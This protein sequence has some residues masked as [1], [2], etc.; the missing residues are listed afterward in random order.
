MT[1]EAK[2]YK[3]FG[4]RKGKNLS[5]LQKKNLT[6]IVHAKSNILLKIVSGIVF[7]LFPFK[8]KFSSE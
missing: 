6:P 8:V 7:P 3:I 5:S 1:E 4:R 2:Q